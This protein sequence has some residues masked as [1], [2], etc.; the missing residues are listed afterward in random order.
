MNAKPTFVGFD[1]RLNEFSELWVA[2][3][4][5][6]NIE[7][8]L[9][10]SVEIVNGFWMGH[11][12][13]P[14][15][16]RHPMRGDAEDRFRLRDSFSKRLQYLRKTIFIHRVH[17]ASVSDEQDRHSAPGHPGSSHIIDRSRAN[18]L[19]VDELLNPRAR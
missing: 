10:E 16:L 18:E 13:D 5:I 3:S 2:L 11:V 4:R 9:G 8:L 17:R 15:A 12:G 1:I 14:G 7:K 19:L 6:L